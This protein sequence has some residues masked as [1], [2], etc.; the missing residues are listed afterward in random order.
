MYN[1]QI[2]LF[3]KPAAN[4]VKAVP[5]DYQAHTHWLPVK[6]MLRI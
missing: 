4:P 3:V 1:V 2:T 6:E 5:W